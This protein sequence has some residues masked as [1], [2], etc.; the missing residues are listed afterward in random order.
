MAAGKKYGGRTKGTPNKVTAL[1]RDVISQTAAN[2]G[3]TERMTAWAKEDPKNE[4]IFWANI[5]TKNL[6][7]DVNITGDMEMVHKYAV[8][9][10]RKIRQA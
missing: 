3:G 5:F 9:E 2:L 8:P 7:H 6:P 10:T 4:A 1:A